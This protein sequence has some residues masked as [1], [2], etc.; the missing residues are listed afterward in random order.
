MKTRIIQNPNTAPGLLVLI[1]VILI[2]L[3][4]FLLKYLSI[5]DLDFE[6][7]FAPFTVITLLAIG[8]KILVYLFI[9]PITFAAKLIS[10][11][12]GS[13]ENPRQL[14]AKEKPIHQLLLVSLLLIIAGTLSPSN[15][16]DERSHK[17]PLELI[18]TTLIIV[19]AGT[20]VY[21]VWNTLKGKEVTKLN[22]KSKD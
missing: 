6:V 19:L 20:A 15:G 8:D 13:F 14:G 12:R 1:S 11:V 4:L 17:T 22:H 2:T 18:T 10:K 5:L 9:S 3:G 21:V 16:V 7:I